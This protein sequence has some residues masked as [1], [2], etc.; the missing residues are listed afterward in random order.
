MVAAGGL[1]NALFIGAA[2]CAGMIVTDTFDSVLVTGLVGSGNGARASRAWLWTMTVAAAGVAIFQ[3]LQLAGIP[4]EVPELSLSAAIV[5]A[6]IGVYA[7][8]LR[9]RINVVADAE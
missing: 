6:L 9:E 2:F 7:Y 5:A 1:E 3:T 8:L 4:L